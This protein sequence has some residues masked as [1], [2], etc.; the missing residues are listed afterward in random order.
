M[1]KFRFVIKGTFHT[2]ADARYASRELVQALNPGANS[3]ILGLTTLDCQLKEVKEKKVDIEV[4]V[5]LEDGTW[6]METVKVPEWVV[7]NEQQEDFLYWVC[8][9]RGTDSEADRLRDA[10]RGAIHYVVHYWG[11]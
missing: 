8:S 2:T 10:H 4:A 3:S 6:V 7:H 1:S 5:V 11:K 9:E